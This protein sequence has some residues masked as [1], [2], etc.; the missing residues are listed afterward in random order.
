MPQ[1]QF[2]TTAKA[3]IG[4]LLMAGVFAVGI[5][6][7]FGS[8]RQLSGEVSI[9][10]EPN[11]KLAKW[12]E[13]RRGVNEA[14]D[15]IRTYSLSR[16][17]NQLDRF[18]DL[19]IELEIKIDSFRQ[20][21]SDSSKF[22][23]DSLKLIAAQQLDILTLL[24]S[25]PK[26]ENKTEAL[27][28]AL[29]A[30]DSLQSGYKALKAE[31]TYTY[32]RKPVI[33][34]N[35]NLVDELSADSSSAGWFER[36]KKKKENDGKSVVN[37]DTVTELETVANIRYSS[38]ATRDTAIRSS[39]EYIRRREQFAEEIR[40][41]G[42]LELL[43]NSQQLDRRMVDISDQFELSE[44]RRSAHLIESA[45]LHTEQRTRR[46]VEWLAYAG[47]VLI[48]IFSSLIYRDTFRARRLRE[49]TERAK[50]AAENLAQ[51]KEDFVA[52]VSHEVRTPLNVINGFST[53]LLKTELDEE[54]EQ[55]AKAI[56]RASDY[57]VALINDILDYAKIGAGRFELE[58]YP[59]NIRELL[60]DVK[61]AFD[62][63]AKNR[64]NT[65]ICAIDS[66]VPALLIGDPMRLRQILFNLVGNALKF[67]ANGEVSIH[68]HAT[69][70][71]SN[72][73]RMIISV[74][75]TGIGIPSEK[76]QHI[77]EAFGQADSSITRKFGGTGLGLT[78]SRF[79][80]QQMHGN[81][82]VTSEPG[83]GSSFTV[84]L[85]FSIGKETLNL[86]PTPASAEKKI[87][88]G[89]EILICDDEELN[90]LVARQLL[91]DYGIIVH[92][93][94]S[95]VEAIDLLHQ[96]AVDLVMMDLQM[97][98]QSGIET[99]KIIRSDHQ[100]QHTLVIAV[101]GNALPEER[102]RSMNSGMDGYLVKPYTETE[103]IQS[104]TDTFA[105]REVV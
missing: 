96:H 40:N 90:R 34:E 4:F 92:E 73:T 30:I 32:V 49:E 80:V 72:S 53:L 48:L 75:D 50:L 86:N 79:I 9:I 94:A 58:N 97:P 8:L 14:S 76:L 27:D 37:Q 23:V 46:L 71:D 39:L 81:I 22:F 19:R 10:N 57:L 84:T 82:Q 98:G 104:L 63:D 89:K 69:R 11:Q 7:V 29:S 102:E 78:I 5:W 95:G 91:E 42:Q 101:T 66:D 38:N 21:V 47:V 20:H 103:L 70:T 54:Q 44:L 1:R 55:H 28:E 6:L 13:L 64:G 33:R 3:L 36:R 51:A 18:E 65:L 15:L 77:F 100:L 83:K 26:R 16:N 2:Y 24:A 17:E 93:A 56:N 62:V 25:A 31:T 85:P 12:N 59:F 45:T 99:L 105:K 60:N 87:L 74:R 67:T 88:H 43:K 68:A 61:T 41:K 52:N 35:N